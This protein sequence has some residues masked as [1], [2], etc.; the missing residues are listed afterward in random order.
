MT[1]TNLG[2]AVPAGGV[3]LDLELTLST[4]SVGDP[5]AYFQDPAGALAGVRINPT[6]PNQ[7][8]TVTINDQGTNPLSVMVSANTLTVSYNGASAGVTSVNSLVNA[9]NGSLGGLVDAFVDGKFF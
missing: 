3:P 8:I 7:A 6:N 4:D 1:V 9:L 2:A 5:I